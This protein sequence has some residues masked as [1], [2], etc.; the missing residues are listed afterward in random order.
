MPQPIL[1]K[2]DQDFDISVDYANGGALTTGGNPRVIAEYWSPPSANLGKSYDGYV[3]AKFRGLPSLDLL[4]RTAYAESV[5]AKARLDADIKASGLVRVTQAVGAYRQIVV[6]A[7]AV[8]R[9]VDAGSTGFAALGDESVRDLAAP[10]DPLDN[11]PVR[12]AISLRFQAGYGADP[13]AFARASVATYF[14]ARGALL[15]APAGVPRIT[16]D[17]V[18]GENKGLLTE[19]ATSKPSAQQREPGDADRQPEFWHLHTVGRRHRLG[20]AVG[21]PGPG[22]RCRERP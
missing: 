21:R 18:T 1:I 7:P 5:N 22:R 13:S 14:D 6:D 2:C 3:R 20:N 9:L 8:E 10:L 19:G 12:P 11:T 15:T 17:P 16:C 4:T